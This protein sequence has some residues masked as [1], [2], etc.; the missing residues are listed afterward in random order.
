MFM[1][2]GGGERRKDR[3]PNLLEQRFVIER[4]D[5]R[6]AGWL[7]RDEGMGTRT[8]KGFADTPCGSS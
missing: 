5:Q 8:R 3:L 7:L 1:I 6:F 2:G 4:G